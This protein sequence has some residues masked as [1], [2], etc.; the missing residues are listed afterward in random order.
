MAGLRS[1]K[2]L[3]SNGRNVTV[4]ETWLGIAKTVDAL[5]AALVVEVE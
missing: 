3:A 2:S 5:E 4:S 1:E